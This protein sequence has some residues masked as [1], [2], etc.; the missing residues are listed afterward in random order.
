MFASVLSMVTATSDEIQELGEKFVQLFYGLL[1]VRPSAVAQFYHEGSQ[2]SRSF[3]ATAGGSCK[4]PAVVAR[5]VSEIREAIMQSVGNKD[6]GHSAPVVVT[7][8]TS[9]HSSALLD[10]RGIMCQI[11]GYITY[12]LESK[13]WRFCQTVFLEPCGEDGT[14]LFVRNDIVQYIEEESLGD[15]VAQSSTTLA[16]TE[17][18]HSEQ[19]QE[20][21]GRQTT[22]PMAGGEG[23]LVP[24]PTPVLMSLASPQPNLQPNGGLPSAAAPSP[25]VETPIP[26]VESASRGAPT[27]WA[28]RAAAAAGPS[29]GLAGTTAGA[30]PSGTVPSSS[31]RVANA[32]MPKP[33]RSAPAEPVP[34]VEP[35]AP[36]AAPLV[37]SA[38]EPSGGSGQAGSAAPVDSAASPASAPESP[39]RERPSP[40]REPPQPRVFGGER[41]LPGST[42]GVKLWVS[43][44]PT[45]DTKSRDCRG[46]PVRARELMDA[47]NQALKDNAPHV[48]GEV[49]EVDRKDERKAFAFAQVSEEQ[50]AKELVM[51]SKAKK[52][53]IRG[54]KL[55]LDLSNYNTTRV[56][57]LYTGGSSSNWNR[58]DRDDDRGNRGKSGKGSGGRGGKSDA[59][60]EGSWRDRGSDRGNDRGGGRG[61]R[62]DRR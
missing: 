24:E 7:N 49:T 33:V 20:D 21:E 59:D 48:S 14:A 18:P 8:V 10:E 44:L 50:A 17:A 35:V 56:E 15:T 57:T 3:A 42:S 40:A 1:A 38:T 46:N 55:N 26:Q 29:T 47:L 52:V 25:Q 34:E 60:A 32:K 37:L 6:P 12:I 19:E 4:R 5:G 9:V 2:L 31:R 28:A 30:T 22:H 61:W 41:G 53:M 43:G 62:G 36:A 58:W 27:S 45:E 39:E 54:E 51:L 23:A 13:V 16:K 11:T